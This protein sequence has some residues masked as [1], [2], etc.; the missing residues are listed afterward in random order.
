MLVC[1][2]FFSCQ[3]EK[4]LP[5]FVLDNISENNNEFQRMII[6]QLSGHKSIPLKHGDYNPELILKLIL[7]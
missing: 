1:L 5:N 7:I 2:S 3:P 4:N 6:A